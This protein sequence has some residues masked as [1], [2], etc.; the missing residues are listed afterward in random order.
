MSEQQQQPQIQQEVPEPCECR[1]AGHI[2]HSTK[3]EG[4]NYQKGWC[5]KCKSWV[6]TEK[7]FCVCCRQKVQHK[8]HYLRCKRIYNK[9]VKD[10]Q[11]I[12]DIYID[13]KKE[14]PEG[15]FAETVFK[16]SKY[17]IPV[18]AL[19]RYAGNGYTRETMVEL[20]DA[21]TRVKNYK[22]KN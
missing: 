3:T 17:H 19:V 12:I 5:E 15:M 6:K 10:N 22:P 18:T 14:I 9:A 4:T 16:D 13:G 21:I 20:Q 11:S 8:V 2:T 1:H 7:V